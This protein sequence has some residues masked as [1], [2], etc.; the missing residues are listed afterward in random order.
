MVISFEQCYHTKCYDKMIFMTKRERFQFSH[1]LEVPDNSLLI[2]LR[3]KQRWLSFKQ[4]KKRHTPNLTP[5]RNDV[6]FRNE[7]KRRKKTQN[8]ALPHLHCY[9]RSITAVI[10]PILIKFIKNSAARLFSVCVYAF[11]C[12]FY[13]VDKYKSNVV[14]T[15]QHHDRE[16]KRDI[17]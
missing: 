11:L 7:Q 1:I 10:R 9:Q 15:P 3:P 13:L 16:H 2:F 6:K 12:R 14:L 17:Q 4:R 8:N 5:I